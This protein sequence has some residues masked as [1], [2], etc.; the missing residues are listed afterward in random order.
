MLGSWGPAPDPAEGLTT[1]P[2]TTRSAAHKNVGGG[3]G[4]GGGWGRRGGGGGWGGGGATSASAYS[5]G[6][7]RKNPKKVENPCAKAYNPRCFLMRDVLHI[8]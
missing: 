6:H 4:V 8:I 7:R 5:L 1:I 3:G 2:Q